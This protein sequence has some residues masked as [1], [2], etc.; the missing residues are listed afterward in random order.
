MEKAKCS[1]VSPLTDG[2]QNNIIILSVLQRCVEK[3]PVEPLVPYSEV[4]FHGQTSEV[5]LSC[6]V[7]SVTSLL[8]EEARTIRRAAVKQQHALHRQH[9]HLIHTEH[10]QK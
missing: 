4:Y 10:S 5:N 9:K 1:H 6:D 3:A 2:A 7:S 8:C